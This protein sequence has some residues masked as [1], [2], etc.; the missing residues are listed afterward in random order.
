MKLCLWFPSAFMSAATSQSWVPALHRQAYQLFPKALPIKH[1]HSLLSLQCLSPGN[2]ATICQA[3][4]CRKLKAIF[5]TSLFIINM[6]NPSHLL[7]PPT[8]SSSQAWSIWPT[9]MSRTCLL[10]FISHHFP[11][12][13]HPDDR[14]DSPKDVPAF[15]FVSPLSSAFYPIATETFYLLFFFL[16]KLKE[17]NNKV[18]SKQY[19]KYRSCHFKIY[20]WIN[21]IKCL[22][23]LNTWN[24]QSSNF[25]KG[26]IEVQLACNKPHLFKEFNLISFFFFKHESAMDLHAFPF[27]IPPPSP[28]HPS[29]S[30]Q[31]TSPEH[32]SHASNLGWGDPLWS[33]SQ[34][35]GNESKNKQMGPN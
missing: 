14:A 4:C 24:C 11:N 8:S 13:G 10:L 21:R 23:I 12:L 22:Y 25:V 33:T 35:I 2:S 29:G 15:N 27:P 30:S 19:P 20:L 1:T 31:C 9:D 34:N 32:L 28:S 18:M 26:F 7:P 16:E 3:A 5:D 17:F 6:P